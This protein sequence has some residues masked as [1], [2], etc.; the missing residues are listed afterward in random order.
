MPLKRSP[1]KSRDKPLRRKKSIKRSEKPLGHGKRYERWRKIKAEGER[2]LFLEN[3]IYCLVCGSSD[4][5]P[6]HAMRRWHAPEMLDLFA[7]L[8]ATHHGR[9]DLLGERFAY[10]LI[11]YLLDC[12][13][14]ECEPEI[15]TS[16]TTAN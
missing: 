14:R 7:P 10:P 8:C 4:T 12:A 15:V 11:V 16:W 3:R 6:A 1:F 13:E 5:T 9:I 2:K